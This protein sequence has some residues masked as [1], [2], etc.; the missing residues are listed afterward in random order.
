MHPAAMLQQHPPLPHHQ[1]QHQ[2]PVV[3]DIEQVRPAADLP[4]IETV[5][6]SVTT[7]KRIDLPLYE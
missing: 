2:H 1:R 7:V 3:V 4:L 5:V 6:T